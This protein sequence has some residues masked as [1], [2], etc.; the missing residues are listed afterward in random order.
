LL[1]S[2]S[3]HIYRDAEIQKMIAGDMSVIGDVTLKKLGMHPAI[4]GLLL[5]FV[6]G[7]EMAMTTSINTLVDILGAPK[8]LSG[9]AIAVL[10]LAHNHDDAGARQIA[11]K[12]VLVGILSYVIDEG[13]AIMP[14]TTREQRR[15]I[16]DNVNPELI[17]AIM[18]MIRRP[19]VSSCF[20]LINALSTSLNG[21]GALSA[22]GEHIIQKAIS[23]VEIFDAVRQQ[24]GKEAFSNVLQNTD[25]RKIL[26]DFLL[27]P[28]QAIAAPNAARP[29]RVLV[30]T[31]L[32]MITLDYEHIS[33]GK[34]T[35]CSWKLS[36][37]REFV[38]TVGILGVWEGERH[39]IESPSR[40]PRV[41][42]YFN[43]AHCPHFHI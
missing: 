27:A 2:P 10:S 28:V 4:G 29:I 9:V 34:S 30:E 14:G 33:D 13:A 12:R 32:A 38:S 17:R 16:M 43:T 8:S 36:S 35:W 23:A 7:D 15:A 19:Q 26:S 21:T 11:L 22:P 1:L 24:G 37:E 41:Y 3:F 40:S 31:I 39:N 42:I 6:R 18:D 5:A 20:G 25:Q